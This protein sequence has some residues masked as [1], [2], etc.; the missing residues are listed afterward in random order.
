MTR[1]EIGARVAAVILSLG[2]DI[3]AEDLR[4]EASLVNNLALDSLA[5]EGLITALKAEIADVD[6]IPWYVTAS[7]SGQDTLASL[8]DFLCAA[9]ATDGR[10]QR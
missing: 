1:E 7:R 9:T 6:F 10:R 2:R 4:P 3:Q 8:I 5:I